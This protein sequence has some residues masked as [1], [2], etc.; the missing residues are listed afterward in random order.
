MDNGDDNY[1]DDE[2]LQTERDGIVSSQSGSILSQWYASNSSDTNS[3]NSYSDS[4]STSS[5]FHL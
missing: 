4:M 3:S 1:S 2:D 5:S